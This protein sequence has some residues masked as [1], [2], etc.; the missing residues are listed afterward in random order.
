MSLEAPVFL[1]GFMG[2]GKSKIGL[3]LAQ[4]L[5]RFFFDTDQMVELRAGKS[6]AAIFA[7]EGEEYFR[8]LE[9]ADEPLRASRLQLASL[10]SRTI[11]QGLDLLGIEIVERM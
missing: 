9:R 4:R 5:G 8:Q 3:I 6:I 1:T 10:T 11:R 2:V 7:D